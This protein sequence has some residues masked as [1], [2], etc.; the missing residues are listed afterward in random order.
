MEKK[1]KGSKKR[2][3]FDARRRQTIQNA[4]EIAKLESRINDPHTNE[5]SKAILRRK[6]AKLQGN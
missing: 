3:D 6:L 2:R 4:A 5:H 1:G